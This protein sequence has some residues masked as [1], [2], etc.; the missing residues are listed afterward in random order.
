MRTHRT[1]WFGSAVI[2]V[3][4]TIW[5]TDF[6]GPLQPDEIERYM[7][8][9][10]ENSPD[11]A[12]ADRFR[13]FMETDTGNQFLMVNIIDMADD[14]A[15]VEGAAPD[16]TAD[17]LMAYYMEHMYAELFARA[18]HPVLAGNAVHDALDLAGI[19]NAEHWEL[20]ALMRYRSRRTLMEIVMIPATAERHE[21]KLAALEKTIA[22]PIETVLYLSDPRLL[23]AL[24]LFSLTALIHIVTSRRGT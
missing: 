11:P 1:L 10:T 2:Y 4:F 23:L 16:A 24:L 7:A 6:G 8:V 9:L 15:P 3:L 17:E 19:E 5:Y 21:Y 13:T 22:F 14:P 18:S 20:A 12:T